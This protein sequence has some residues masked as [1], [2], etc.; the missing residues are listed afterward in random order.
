MVVLG[1]VGGGRRSE[2]PLYCA[3]VGIGRTL[4]RMFDGASSISSRS[5]PSSIT[6]NLHVYP[7]QYINEIVSLESTPSQTCQLNFMKGDS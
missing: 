1:G 2:V 3:T 6:G 4:Q 7:T 5:S